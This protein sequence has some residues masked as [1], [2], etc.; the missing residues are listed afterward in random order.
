MI[1]DLDGTL[2]DTIP[3]HALSFQRLFLIFGKKISIKKIMPFMRLPT[4]KI[5]MG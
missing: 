1:F 5:V 2:I 4:E 3:L